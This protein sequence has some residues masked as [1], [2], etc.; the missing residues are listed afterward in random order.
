MDAGWAAAIFGLVGSLVG[1]LGSV[2]GLI[3]T[4]RQRE[5]RDR[6]KQVTDM[7]LA[8]YKLRTELAMSGKFPNAATKPLVS[9]LYFNDLLLRTMD[10]GQLTEDQLRE[11]FNKSDDFEKL[12]QK[13]FF[14]LAKS[15]IVN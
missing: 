13:L 3:W 6:S 7:A 5:K 11:I 8:D 4:S 10:K 2:G 1:S 15:R 14:E 9:Y 12:F